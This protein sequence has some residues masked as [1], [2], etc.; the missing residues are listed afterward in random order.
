MYTPISAHVLVGAEEE[1]LKGFLDQVYPWFDE[2]IMVLDSDN[3]SKTVC[4]DIIT[5]FKEEHKDTKI[6]IF[7]RPLQQDFAGQT[8]FAIEQC[9]HEW[10][11]KLDVDE[12]FSTNFL[13]HLRSIIDAG[14]AD[15]PN[16][17]VVG[18]PRI[19]TLDGKV[20]NDIP[21]EHWFTPEFDQYPYQTQG[22]KNPDIQFRLHKKDAL[23][24]GK[25]HEVPEPVA[26][27]D[28]DR[29]R[30]VIDFPFEHPKSRERQ[31]RQEK[32]YSKI[33]GEKQKK[34]EVTKY[35]YDSV[36][37]TIE[38]ITEHARKEV[39]E[40]VRRGKNV[41]LLDTNYRTGFETEL[42]QC[43]QPIPID[44]NEYVTIVNQPPPRW[45]NHPYYKNRIGYLAFEGMINQE[46]TQIINESNIRELWTPSTYCKTMFEKS[47]VQK[48]ITVIPHGVDTTVWK[49]KKKGELSP[50]IK[51]LKKDDEFLV[52][53]VGTYH[54]NRKG[55]DLVL[56]AFSDG[57]RG[58]DKVKLVVKVNKIYNPGDSF[59]N[60]ARRY[61]EKT[62]NTNIEFIDEDL[63][64]TE[65]VDLFN[66]ADV[67]VAPHRAE[68]FGINILNAMAVGTPVITTKATGNLDFCNDENVVFIE[69]TMPV[70]APWLMP[71]ERARWVEPD[72]RELTK[73]M[74]KVYKNYS[75]Y[76][77]KAKKNPQYIIDNWT[78]QHTVD[79]IEERVKT[80]FR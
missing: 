18:F 79:K 48:P 22:V 21:R 47:G 53:A 9:Q 29:I 60:Y 33:V 44:S 25:V 52:L 27:R 23:W 38:G 74:L 19:N 58:E 50:R 32:F 80:I 3:K 26:K 49:P 57:F 65:L 72:L 7:E 20:S 71:Y 11:M 42:E 24:I 59:V 37:Y 17:E 6:K 67:Y 78:W 63:T 68:G 1:L 56:K 43:H 75:T 10:T 46:W 15:N 39:S 16:L 64:E 41:Y 8:N 36:V 70:Y 45:D 66:I 51:A 31:M 62:G 61:V 77:H 54:N 76:Q 55:L 40:L 35:I 2:F 73:T 30:I 5:K 69:K 4:T 14:L 28:D 12:K 13:A 34:A